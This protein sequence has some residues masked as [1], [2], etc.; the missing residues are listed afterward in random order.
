MFRF[1]SAIG[2]QITFKLGAEE[3]FRAKILFHIRAHPFGAFLFDDDLE[4]LQREAFVH[5]GADQGLRL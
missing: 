2:I 1:L 3:G 5:P 4:V